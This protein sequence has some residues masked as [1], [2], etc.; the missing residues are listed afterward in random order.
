MDESA[1]PRLDCLWWM[2]LNLFINF[3]ALSAKV[4]E[5]LAPMMASIPVIPVTQRSLVLLVH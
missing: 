4:P 1:F 2:Y 5:S 3:E